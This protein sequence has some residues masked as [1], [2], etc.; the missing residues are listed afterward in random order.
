[1]ATDK[2]TGVA[3]GRELF[4]R[5]HTRK[6]RPSAPEARE[7]NTPNPEKAAAPKRGTKG[8]ATGRALYESHGAWDP[9]DVQTGEEGTEV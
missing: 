3:A 1:M 4:D 7:R 6:E 8:V 2:T 5:L 9:A